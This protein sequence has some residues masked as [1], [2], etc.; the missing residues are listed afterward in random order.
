MN[1][2]RD[3]LA[4]TG[5]YLQRILFSY[6]KQTFYL[7]YMEFPPDPQQKS[8]MLPLISNF[9]IINFDS[10]SGQT[11]NQD[12]WSKSIPELKSQNN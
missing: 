6:F 5:H 12:S 7:T 3:Y 1:C 8:I 2:V 10:F 4:S 11:E 9:L